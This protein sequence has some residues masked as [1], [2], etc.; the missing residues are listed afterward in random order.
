MLFR[1]PPAV[2]RD[3]P[4][5]AERAGVRP[6]RL[7]L[8]VAHADAARADAGARRRWGVLLAAIIW[9]WPSPPR[10][11]AIASLAFPVYYTRAVA[12]CCTSAAVCAHARPRVTDALATAGPRPRGALRVP[13]RLHRHH[14][15]L[16]D[17]AGLGGLQAAPRRRRHVVLRRRRPA[18]VPDGRAAARRRRSTRSRPTCARRHRRRGPPLLPSS[19]H[20]SDRPR[21]RGVARRARRGIARRRQHADAAA[22]AD[23]V[24]VEQADARRARRR[25]R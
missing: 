23:A 15:R 21:P 7:R 6:H 14:R 2:Q 17:A 18:V 12:R 10:W 4:A 11:L 20:R 8:S 22:G 9:L 24:P 25:K 1:V 13:R 19:R 16:V 3:R 5:G